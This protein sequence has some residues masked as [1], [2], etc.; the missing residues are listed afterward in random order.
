MSDA[1]LR[2]HAPRFRLGAVVAT[3]G[4]LDALSRHPSLL[5]QIVG[6]HARC[7]WGEVDAE[8]RRANDRALTSGDR[9][10]SAY[11]TP[12]GVRVWVLTEADRSATTLLLPEEY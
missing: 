1:L 9:L 7:D 6:R 11:T 10:M 3:P 4:A 2:G 5:H 8:D 12:E